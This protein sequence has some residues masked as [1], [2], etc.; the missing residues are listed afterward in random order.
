MCV[1][2]FVYPVGGLEHFLFSIIYGRILPID[3]KYFSRWL[4][5]PTSMSLLIVFGDTQNSNQYNPFPYSTLLQNSPSSDL[6]SERC[7]PGGRYGYRA[8]HLEVCKY[9]GFYII[10][11]P[12][13]KS[14]S[15]SFSVF[16]GLLQ[17]VISA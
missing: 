6:S 1:Y 4:K 16:R 2:F 12:S 13:W 10:E 9:E 8:G 7:D 17:C 5:P 3:F 15:A 11:R 14:T